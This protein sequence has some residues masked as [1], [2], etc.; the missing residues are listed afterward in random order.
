MPNVRHLLYRSMS[1]IWRRS[2]LRDWLLAEVPT[3]ELDLAGDRAIE[4]P[5]CL[6]FLTRPECRVLD[7]GSVGSPLTGAAW[8]LGHEVVSVDLRPIEYELEGMKF[9]RGDMTKLD[10]P[11]YSFDVILLC[12]TVEH[13][14]LAGRYGSPDIPDGDLQTMERCRDWLTPK[15]KA[16]LTIPVG[17]DAT[18]APR[19][20][21]YGHQ[22]LPRLLSGYTVVRKEFWK[23]N[24]HNRW[25]QVSEQ[26]AMQTDGTDSPYAL[27]LFEL[28]L[29]ARKQP[30]AM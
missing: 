12:S 17:L 28:A 13:I 24:D 10:L 19:H 23:K 2:G 25:V 1:A 5:W 29:Q 22:R 3:K 11:R 26:T 8:R 9:I 21:I 14:G 27:G 6:Q 7:I 20:R 4:F 15:G 18:V 16:V 30:S